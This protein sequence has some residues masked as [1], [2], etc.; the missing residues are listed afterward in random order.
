MKEIKL[1]KG[2]SIITMLLTMDGTPICNLEKKGCQVR[3][4]LY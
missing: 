3:K 2:R 4:Y 1:Y